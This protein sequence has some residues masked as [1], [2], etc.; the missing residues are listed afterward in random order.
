MGAGRRSLGLAACSSLA[1]G[2]PGKVR[3]L[4]VSAESSVLF[5]GFVRI[6]YKIIGEM[7]SIWLELHARLRCEEDAW[8]GAGH[9]RRLPALA[10]QSG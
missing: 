3:V 10:A 1:T 2:R 4:A 6:E 9:P 8:R 7:H 5:G